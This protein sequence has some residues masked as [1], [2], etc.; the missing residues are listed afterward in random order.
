MV[1]GSLQSVLGESSVILIFQIRTGDFLTYEEQGP[2][3]YEDSDQ[4][5]QMNCDRTE[6]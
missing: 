4:Q 5:Q 6:D 3:D 2:V 1:L